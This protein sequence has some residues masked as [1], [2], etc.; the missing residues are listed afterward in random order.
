M[1]KGVSKKLCTTGEGTWFCNDDG[2][3]KPGVAIGLSL[4]FG[5]GTALVC[6]PFYRRIRTSVNEEFSEDV[7]ERKEEAKKAKAAAAEQ[8]TADDVEAP[9][10][11]AGGKMIIR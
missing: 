4:L 11:S 10:P 6:I 9:K 5:V 8:K 7:L 1:S 2:K 3:P